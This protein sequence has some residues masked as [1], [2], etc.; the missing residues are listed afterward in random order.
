LN[1]VSWWKVQPNQGDAY[2]WSALAKFEQ[3]LLASVK[4]GLTPIVTIN[5]SPR[6][7]TVI[8]DACGAVRSD[9]FVDLANFMEALVARYSKPPFNVRHWELF[10]EVDVEFELVP[11]KD[12][13]LGC[14]GD[15]NDPYF[16]GRHYGNMLKVVY[17]AI[18]RANNQ[19]KVLAGAFIL[20][21]P[22]S[23]TPYI[24]KPE[25][26][27]PGMLEAG[28]APYF[29][30]LSFHSH[31]WYWLS[32]YQ[33]NAPNNDWAPYGS[34][35]DA[36]AHYFKQVLNKYGI[37]KPL[38]MN[39]SAFICPDI[40]G[41][42]EACLNPPQAFFDEQANFVIRGY[43]SALAAGVEMIAWYTIEEQGWNHSGLLDTSNI[44]RPVFKAYKTLIEQI[45][46][47]QLPAAAVDY[48]EGVRG[49]RFN[50][51]NRVVDVV[52]TSFLY[53][54]PKT[55]SWPA[56][57]HIAMYDRFGQ[58]LTPNI[59]DGN[60]TYSVNLQPIFIHRKP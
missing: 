5:R 41:F 50:I 4:L 32:P 37:T 17:P 13:P 42:R 3:E 30:I 19:A 11:V 58:S 18:K 34:S 51:G 35:V 12:G 49:W 1:G 7:A 59:T 20:I 31:G 45:S 33:D 29:D 25:Q 36:K 47:A 27:L 9:R 6:W 22:N 54:G 39:E 24:G 52:Y 48:G 10:N 21:S 53:T 8:P 38:F 60:A 16:G 56:G 55:I 40:E 43:S 28:A 23:Q 57:S 26:F 46:G 2:N 15:R 14:W 44:P